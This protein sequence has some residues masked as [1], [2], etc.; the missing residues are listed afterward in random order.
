MEVATN[1]AVHGTLRPSENLWQQLRAT[2][3]RSSIRRLVTSRSLAVW[4][5]EL[6]RNIAVARLLARCIT[7]RRQEEQPDEQE[8]QQQ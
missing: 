2:R 1:V 7:E 4:R 8:Q 6:A 5:R 3:H